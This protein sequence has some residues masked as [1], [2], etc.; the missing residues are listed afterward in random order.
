MG[1][2]QAVVAASVWQDYRN[3][4]QCQQQAPLVS[5]HILHM[6]CSGDSVCIFQSILDRQGCQKAARLGGW[7]ASGSKRGGGGGRGRTEDFIYDVQI[8][9]GQHGLQKRRKSFN[10]CDKQ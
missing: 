1:F 3:F 4:R 10:Q 6:Q 9:S 5:K 2:V 8:V 7:G